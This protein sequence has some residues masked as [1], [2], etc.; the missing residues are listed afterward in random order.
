MII[1]GSVRRYQSMK[2]RDVCVK[3]R[4][5]IRRERTIFQTLI[6]F[7]CK[8]SQKKACSDVLKLI[9]GNRCRE[10][11]RC[12]TFGLTYMSVPLTSVRRIHHDSLKTI[13]AA[14]RDIKTSFAWIIVVHVHD[15]PR[16]T[17]NRSAQP[18][19]RS[20]F[21]IPDK[22]TKSSSWTEKL[23]D[24]PLVPTVPYSQRG[25]TKLISHTWSL[26]N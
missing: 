24:I 11:S 6:C 18:I 22:S 26:Q 8:R 7:N 12:R 19:E 10:K 17:R 4:L 25:N 14:S 20:L 21:Q 13:N 23:P 15:F 16:S 3:R 9:R 1:T 2:T 5:V